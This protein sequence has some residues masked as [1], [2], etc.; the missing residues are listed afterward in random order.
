MSL[1]S[2]DLKS[3]RVRSSKSPRHQRYQPCLA[4]Q[5]PAGDPFALDLLKQ[6]HV[7]IS[8]K[9]SEIRL[10]RSV[11]GLSR[12][13]CSVIGRDVRL[14]IPACRAVFIQGQPPQGTL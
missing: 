4:L 10:E 9:R 3:P 11:Y 5:H 2:F 1:L 6:R 8:F 13:G 14:V 7:R 12:R